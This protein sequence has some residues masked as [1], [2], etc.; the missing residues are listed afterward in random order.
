MKQLILFTE[1]YNLFLDELEQ[2]KGK[3]V[4]QLTDYAVIA[5][6]PEDLTPDSLRF[7]T[8]RPDFDID[9]QTDSILRRTLVQKKG[10]DV[11]GAKSSHVNTF[12][13][14]VNASFARAY[15]K[16][17]YLFFGRHYAR[18]SEGSPYLD[19]GYPK[20]IAGNWKGLPKS[21][22][23]GIDAVFQHLSDEK[24]YIF[25]GDQ[26]L[27]YSSIPKGVDPG[28]P[29]P[30]AGNWKGLPKSFE[31]GIDTVFQRQS[32]GKIYIFKGDQYVRMNTI[33]EGVEV[34]YPKS[35][36]LMWPGLPADFQSGI[37]AALMRKENGKIYFFKGTQYIRFTD[38]NKGVDEGYPKPIA[39]NW[40][41]QLKDV[42]FGL[43]KKPEPDSGGT[44]TSVAINSKGQV[45]EVHCSEVAS[46]MWH[47][48]GQT[49]QM[50]VKWE[51]SVHYDYGADP[52][53]S[54]NDQGTLVE[55]HKSQS[56][57]SLWYH[58]GK[59]QNNL[60]SWGPSHEYDKGEL[61]SVAINNEHWCVEVHGSQ[62][63]AKG[64]WYRLG[65]VDPRSDK[66]VWQFENSVRYGSGYRPR[67]AMNN[68]G[69]VVE[70]HTNESGNDN[71]WYTVGQL[72]TKE[73]KIDWGKAVWLSKGSTPTV[74]LD[75]E[76]FVIE[77]H[78]GVKSV[79][80]WSSVG[81]VYVEKKQIE[82]ANAKHFN[83]G[84]KP[85]VACALDGSIAIQTHE[86]DVVENTIWYSTSLITERKKWM[87][88][89]YDHLKNKPLWQI[90]IPGSHDAGAYKMSETRVPSK[91]RTLKFDKINIGKITRL[92]SETQFLTLGQ[93]LNAGARFFDL[94]PTKHDGRFYAY[95]DNIGASFHDMLDDIQSFLR[96]TSRELI[97]LKI[98]TFCSFN[99]EQHRE[100]SQLIQD[101][102]GPYIRK[103]QGNPLTSTF[104]TLVQDGSNVIV[105]YDADFTPFPNAFYRGISI[106]DKYANKDDY[107][108]MRKD[109]L[110]KLISNPGNAKQLF[111][112]SWTLTFKDVWS[113][114]NKG[115]KITLHDISKAA[116][117]NLGQFLATAPK[118]KQINIVYVDFLE[119][120]RVTD[121]VITLNRNA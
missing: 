71:L 45:L 84:A 77:T 78:N 83:D 36:A 32:D 115:I 20:P 60:V 93:Q 22:E 28:Y 19:S 75:D 110:E 48:I 46:K 114:I 57:V 33:E 72:N 79:K 85:S 73:K 105:W 100:F 7:A 70:I 30:I 113:I 68:Q 101:K 119:D 11:S 106:Y 16:K 54:M 17:I 99:E 66:I 43:S 35:I 52:F 108:E 25:K 80:L 65:K 41:N 55:V 4:E 3:V 29:K 90:T 69:V 95:H 76:G 102:I 92:F 59:L 6:I 37:D 120:A 86:S 67:V 94:R 13:I 12:F 34:G 38:V 103:P 107:E 91:C 98:S 74:A 15:N 117:G 5:D 63:S 56:S 14:G 88:H 47:R 50:D 111:L 62:G 2:I 44:R 109:Q 18:L 42:T 40:F 121:C 96:S 49:T 104:D 9:D 87:E 1:N 64:L 23:A 10:N 97:I 51:K 58:I 112:L 53:I 89:M 116:N 118:D 26:Y 81:K 82:W 8:E 21:F 61:P 31:A 39:I 24:I 27:R